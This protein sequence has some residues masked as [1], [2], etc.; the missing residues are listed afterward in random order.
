MTK[1]ERNKVYYRGTEKSGDNK[2]S[3]KWKYVK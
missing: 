3:I 1:N 2:I